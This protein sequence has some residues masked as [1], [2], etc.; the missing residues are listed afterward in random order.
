MSLESTTRSSYYLNHYVNLIIK[1]S[2]IC[3][4]FFFSFS[5]SNHHFSTRLLLQAFSY[6]CLGG[7]SSGREKDKE[8]EDWKNPHGDG[9]A[10]YEFTDVLREY[11]TL[12]T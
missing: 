6:Q 4:I 5:L 7:D 8:T 12:I 10:C 1:L 2:Y 9:R 3:L 11:R